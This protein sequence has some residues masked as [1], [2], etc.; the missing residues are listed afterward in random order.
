[1]L[2]TDLVSR[3]Q[4]IAT[5]VSFPARLI[6][7]VLFLLFLLSWRAQKSVDV[8][9]LEFSLCAKSVT[10]ILLNA[11]TQTWLSSL[12]VPYSQ[13][14][15]AY[16]FNIYI[17]YLVIMAVAETYHSPK[18]W[19]TWLISLIVSISVLTVYML[20]AHNLNYGSY[21]IIYRKQYSIAW[22]YISESLKRN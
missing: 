19:D 12:P 14:D 21:K 22:I 3:V 7:S 6:C 15:H 18:F 10:I 17:P 2:G 5:Y 1:M 9:F 4:Y 11:W 20:L 13:Y 8:V 16:I